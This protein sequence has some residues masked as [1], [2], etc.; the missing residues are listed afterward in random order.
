MKVLFHIDEQAKWGMVLANVKNFL[1][2]EEGAQIEV[3]ANGPAVKEYVNQLD[4][5]LKDKV[6]FVVCQNAMNGNG[7]TKDQLDPAVRIVKAGVV[8]IA[9]KQF[10]GFAYIK[11]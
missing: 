7:L 4:E 11:P 6:D 3:V 2:E 5:K 1:K 10:E 9:K 8:E